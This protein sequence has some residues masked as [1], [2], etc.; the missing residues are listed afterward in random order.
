MVARAEEIGRLFSELRR[1]HVLRVALGY[2]AAAWI[3]IEIVSTVLPILG[4]PDAAVRAF[5]IL[6]GASFPAVVAL[7]WIFD[8]TTDGIRRTPALHTLEG[9]GR[10]AAGNGRA[11]DADGRRAEVEVPR[12]SSRVDAPGPLPMVLALPFV[13]RS[14]G[15]DHQ[16]LADGITEDLI[17][18]LARVPGLRVV[19]QTT[20]FALARSGLDAREAGARLGAGTVVEGG[21]R[22]IGDR[23]RLNVRLVDAANGVAGWAEVFDRDLDDLFAVQD[24]VA[25]AIVRT[26]RRRLIEGGDG[27]SAE[28]VGTGTPS[29]PIV[30]SSTH[31]LRA[32]TLYLR[33]RALWKQRSPAA[34]DEAQRLFEE[35]ISRDPEFAHAHAGLADVHSVRLDYGLVAPEE[36]LPLA[37]RSAMEGLRLGKDLAEVHTAA[38][39]VRQMEGSWRLARAE[40]LRALELNPGYEVAR[41]RYALLLAWL[42]RTREARRQIDLARELDPFS[43]LV[44]ATVA[45][46]EYYAGS[47]DEAVL[48]ARDALAASP[49]L[50]TARVVLSLAQIAAGRVDAAVDE[51][52]AT[53][54]QAGD[55]G[56]IRALLVHA[57]GRQGERAAAATEIERLREGSASRYVSPYCMAVA[58]L[59]TGDREGALSALERAVTARVPQVVY[60]RAEPI[61]APLA[62]DPRFRELLSRADLVDPLGPR[63]EVPARRDE[64]RRTEKV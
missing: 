46:I 43:P 10:D 20:A 1:R 28:T 2:G 18:G 30:R 23:M 32:Y 54:R 33:G 34:L 40:F 52:R 62:S 53:L 14:P 8:I 56:G 48:I 26:L 36:G 44:T 57:L 38:A 41:H 15:G 27:T 7:A 64:P 61:F 60:L 19:A 12:A 49:G 9:A 6:V 51:L 37:R 25:T 39:L 29:G 42:G 22:V 4:G 5:T 24:E 13:D 45:W 63:T 11:A 17:N 55:A 47:Y 50:T 16:L 59:G 58:L 3:M 35:A 21:L 31:D